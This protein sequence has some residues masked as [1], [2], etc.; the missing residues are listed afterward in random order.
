[1]WNMEYVRIIRPTLDIMLKK[2]CFALVIRSTQNINVKMTSVLLYFATLLFKN[3][4]EM[5]LK[6]SLSN[7]EAGGCSL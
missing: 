6:I 3:N 1:M 7:W 5:V 2:S 4:S